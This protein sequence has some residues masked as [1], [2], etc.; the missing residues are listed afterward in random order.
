MVCQ[1]FVS[2]GQRWQEEMVAVH[3]M[4]YKAGLSI[5]E[6]VSIIYMLEKV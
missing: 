4:K 3:C 6:D 2:L 1:L 5:G